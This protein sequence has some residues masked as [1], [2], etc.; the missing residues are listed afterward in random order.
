MTIGFQIPPGFAD[1]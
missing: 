1:S